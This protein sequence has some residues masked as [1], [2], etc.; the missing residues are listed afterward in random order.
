MKAITIGVVEDDPLVEIVSVF[1]F[2]SLNM[3]GTYV[4]ANYIKRRMH[5][6][7]VSLYCNQFSLL[8][9]YGNNTN[10]TFLVKIDHDNGTVKNHLSHILAR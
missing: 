3:Y 4:Y 1:P 9:A 8:I 2:L 5:P 6:Y 10:V 7:L